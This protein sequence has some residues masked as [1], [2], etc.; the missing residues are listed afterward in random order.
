M[1]SVTQS[2]QKRFLYLFVIPRAAR[3]RSLPGCHEPRAPIAKPYTEQVLPC[4][5]KWFLKCSYFTS[6]RAAASSRASSP[7]SKGQ[8]TS[9]ID[10]WLLSSITMSG[11]TVELL[12]AT[13]WL[14]EMLPDWTA[15]VRR[16]TILSWRSVMD[17]MLVG[18]WH[19][20]WGR[21]SGCSQ[22]WQVGSQSDQ[23]LLTEFVW[24]T[25]RRARWTK[26]QSLK[27][28]LR[29]VNSHENPLAKRSFWRDLATLP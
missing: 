7:L 19:S 1:T 20:R 21:V 5:S 23:V 13:V 2:L 4:A 15:L 16:S 24:R 18:Q 27:R 26:R 6:L 14:V 10:T 22:W 29:P 9:M 8:Q 12:S 17:V 28:M 11:R 3:T 25:F